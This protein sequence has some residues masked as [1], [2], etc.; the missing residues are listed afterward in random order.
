MLDRNDLQH[1]FKFRCVR[2]CPEAHAMTMPVTH[3]TVKG[4]L[5]AVSHCPRCNCCSRAA[6]TLVSE[7]EDEEQAAASVREVGEPAI[8]IQDLPTAPGE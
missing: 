2:V 1:P 7:F 5:I 6:A 3:E 4:F 8:R